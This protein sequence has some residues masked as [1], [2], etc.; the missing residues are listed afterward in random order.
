YETAYTEGDFLGV[1][2]KWGG[3]DSLFQFSEKLAD[4]YGAGTTTYDEVFSCM[5]GVDCSG[6]VS[7]VWGTSQKY[8]TSTFSQITHEIPVGQLLPGDAFND[9]GTHCALYSHTLDSGEPYLIEAVYFNTHLNA[10]GG[11]SWVDGFK[12]IRHDDITGTSVADPAG[13]LNHPIDVG[14][15]PYTDSRD[16]TSAPSD[17]LDGCAAAAGSNESGR[18]FVYRVEVTQPGMLTASVADDA[19]ADID[20]HLYGS[21]NT[22]DCA[23]RGDATFTAPVDCGTYYVVADTFRSSGG[24]LAG[25]YDL[26]ISQAPSGGAC[27]DGA[28]A[29]EPLGGLGAAC[30][31]PEHEALPFC[32]PTLGGAD[33]C[34]YT[35]GEGSTSFC[36]RPCAAGDDCGDM[37]GGG[38]CQDIGS[39]ELYCMTADFCPDDAPDGDDDQSSGP[40]GGPGEGGGEGGGGGGGGSGDDASGGGCAA[41]GGGGAW[42]ALLGLALALRRS[43]R[44]RGDARSR[45]RRSRRR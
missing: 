42:L 30:A 21:W 33:V 40:D 9:A 39:G 17:L 34:I 43:G 41:G 19:G 28:P 11:W 15:L 27:G 23:A 10:T 1:A 4:G 14:A 24:D 35:S 8:G 16:T 12:S 3:F 29:Y 7:R 22:S 31:Y 25:A 2:Y 45:G 13:T 38:C 36:S 37:P 44:T 18:E 26:T 32:N 20:V 6:F 5:T